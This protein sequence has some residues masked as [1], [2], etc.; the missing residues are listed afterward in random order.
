RR[1]K[2]VAGAS[3][4]VAGGGAYKDGQHAPS[5]LPATGFEGDPALAALYF[6]FGRYMLIASSRAGSEPATLQG[7][8][9]ELLNPPWESKY[10]TN[11]NLEMNY[12]PAEP[13]NLSEC[14]GP[15]FDLIDDLAISGGRTAREQYRARG[16]V[17]HHN[18]D[19]WRGTAPINNIDGIW[20][21]GGAWLCYH[22]WEHY[23][24]TDDKEFLARRAY[25]AMKGASLFFL[26]SLV[27]DPT[28]GWLVTNASYSPE[29][30]ALSDAT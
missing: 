27:P 17:L 12:W 4:A 15:L 1:L 23:L 19:H 24:F 20:P 16:W 9:N 26:D 29:Q 10:T 7:V 5:P 2:D 6:Q 25:P 21:T 13:A 8:W 30:G 11:I 18:T 3:N 22:L 28:T 14:T